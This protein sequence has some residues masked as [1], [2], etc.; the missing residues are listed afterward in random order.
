[1]CCPR[2]VTLLSTKVFGAFLAPDVM[3]LHRVAEIGVLRA[4][5]DFGPLGVDVEAVTEPWGER[6]RIPSGRVLRC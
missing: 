1:M 5:Y 4:G 2:W 3:L 6:R